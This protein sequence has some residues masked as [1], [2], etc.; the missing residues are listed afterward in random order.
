MC[1]DIHSHSFFRQKTIVPR[2]AGPGRT[3]TRA[4]AEKHVPLVA[5][6]R[7]RFRH[8]R[9][10]TKPSSRSNSVGR[11]RAI[12]QLK[13]VFVAELPERELVLSLF[14]TVMRL[15]QLD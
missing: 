15:R 4:R 11:R 1:A 13:G 3:S 2:N 8:H 12:Q 9:R 5:L 7:L 14:D 6:L 10:T